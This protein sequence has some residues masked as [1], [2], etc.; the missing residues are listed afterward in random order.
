MDILRDDES[1]ELKYKR[2]GRLDMSH[3]FLHHIRRNQIARDDY[4]KE[5]KLA[6]ELQRRR[7]TTTPRRPRRPDIQVYHPRRR[8]DSEP[9]ASA[10]AEEWNESGSSTETET[11][12]NELFWL[13][14]Q[15]DSG[16]ITSVLVHKDDTPARVVEHVT[17][18]NILDLAMRA[19]LEARIRTEMDK[20]RD[21]R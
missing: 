5:V 13:D 21:K 8:H 4:D 12:G 9:G 14:Y 16:T 1:H 19:A 3:G 7:C 6:T 2:G 11:Q 10:E 20:R 17:E 18:K 15:A